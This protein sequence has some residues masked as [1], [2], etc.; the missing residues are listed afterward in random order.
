M[1]EMELPYQA[2]NS[3]LLQKIF[4]NKQEE[5]RVMRN[6]KTQT[7]SRHSRK[8]SLRLNICLLCGDMAKFAGYSIGIAQIDD[9]TEE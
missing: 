4:E 1:K 7:I 2:G 3:T 8:L 9:K 5:K 6:P